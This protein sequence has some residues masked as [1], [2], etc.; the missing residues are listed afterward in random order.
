MPKFSSEHQPQTAERKKRSRSRSINQRTFRKYTQKKQYPLE[1][2]QLYWESLGFVHLD[3]DYVPP[4]VSQQ[5]S[6]VSR[7]KS[8]P[9]EKKK[10]SED[11]WRYVIHFVYEEILDSPPR[12]EWKNND[13]KG[14]TIVEIMK[15]LHIPTGSRSKV[16]NVL[17][18]VES[19][20]I[21]GEEPD[22]SRKKRMVGPVPRKL[23]EGSIYEWL[24]ADY[25]EQGCGPVL[26]AFFVNIHLR[27]DNVRY[28]IS[29]YYIRSLMSRLDPIISKIHK[30]PQSRSQHMVWICACYNWVVQLLVRLGEYASST[31]DF[32]DGVIPKWADVNILKS[33]N[34]IISIHQVVFF[35]EMHKK[36]IIGM[37]SLAY[38]RLQT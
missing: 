14:G 9:D 21:R 1:Y 25:L 23:P 19:D 11:E 16:E 15:L 6:Q 7:N 3:S 2:Y 24:A 17:N 31:N 18:K 8:A 36:Q 29:E 33:S 27:D 12:S 10:R 26:T 13:R 38:D 32:D 37:A 22:L 28:T 34:F 5:S 35:D 30:K 4:L 20:R